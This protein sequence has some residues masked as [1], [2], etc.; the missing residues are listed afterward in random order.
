MKK[1]V[2]IVFILLVACTTFIIYN[3]PTIGNLWFLVTGRGFFIPSE[4]SVFLFKITQYN[5][6]SG[7]WWLYGEDKD[8][9]YALHEKY[10]VYLVFRR[11]EVK[12]CLGF[13]AQKQRTWCLELTRRVDYQ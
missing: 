7:E 12:Q 1:L 3:T 2:I 11:V 9:F 4:S 5:S 6:G 10:P 8:H 13:H